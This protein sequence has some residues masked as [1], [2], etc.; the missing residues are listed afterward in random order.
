[1][2]KDN[3]NNLAL[4]VQSLDEELQKL[5][6]QIG[7]HKEKKA[8][9]VFSR[10]VKFPSYYESLDDEL[11]KLMKQIGYHKEKKTVFFHIM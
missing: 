8:V 5:K 7:Y 1:M 9:S 2:K 10:Y 4:L 6:K 3:S 11:R